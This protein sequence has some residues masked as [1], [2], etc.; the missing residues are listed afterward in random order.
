[1]YY[2]AMSHETAEAQRAS[3]RD[4]IVI[5]AALPHLLGFIV[6]AAIA[7]TLHTLISPAAEGLP[8]PIDPQLWTSTD[9]ERFVSALHLWAAL[10]TAATVS[11]LI[12]IAHALNLIY[13]E[14]G[15]DWFG[16]FVIIIVTFAAMIFFTDG[17]T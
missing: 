5:G 3:L 6:V 4:R 16:V 2:V 15:R 9:R 12:L 17:G 10:A 1:M 8:A 13:R 11:V 7:F 14:A